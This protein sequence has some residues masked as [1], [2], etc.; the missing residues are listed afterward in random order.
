MN[1]EA[2]SISQKNVQQENAD[3]Q[4][5]TSLNLVSLSNA[6]KSHTTAD[7]RTQGDKDNSQH[8]VSSA[9]RS[10]SGIDEDTANPYSSAH[11]KQFLH[12]MAHADTLSIPDDSHRQGSGQAITSLPVQ[13]FLRRWGALEDLG[14]NV[15]ELCRLT[16]SWRYGV[17]IR[18]PVSKAVE[19]GVLDTDID[20]G[21]AF[22]YVRNASGK[23]TNVIST[24]PVDH[25]DF[26]KFSVRLKFAAGMIDGAN[27]YPLKGGPMLTY[28][29]PI[30]RRGY[31]QAVALMQEEKLHP[32]S[33]SPLNICP[34]LPIKVGQEIGLPIPSG[35]SPV[36]LGFLWVPFRNPYGL[37]NQLNRAMNPKLLPK[38]EFEGP[39]LSNVYGL[40]G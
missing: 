30:T 23:V 4:N 9:H 18:L 36:K 33:Y 13:G 17:G 3:L 11:L 25:L 37:A 29:Y 6:T 32:D 24:G 15:F 34:T 35:I 10:M 16:L 21:H 40:A 26:S 8:L 22:A 39:A 7:H 38:S 27:N 14:G 19:H 28:E 12:E 1:I 20:P 5:S 31:E 2:D